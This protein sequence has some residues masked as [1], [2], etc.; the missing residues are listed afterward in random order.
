MA[1]VMKSW[2]SNGDGGKSSS[3]GGGYIENFKGGGNR[4]GPYDGGW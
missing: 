2:T 1:A 4:S 3:K